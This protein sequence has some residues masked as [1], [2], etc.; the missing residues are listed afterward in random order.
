MDKRSHRYP[1]SS[2][3]WSPSPS[4]VLLF[5]LLSAL[6]LASAGVNNSAL[7]PSQG[8]TCFVGTVENMCSSSLAIVANATQQWDECW[9]CTN[10]HFQTIKVGGCFSNF[11]LHLLTP[12]CSESKATCIHEGR[13]GMSFTTCASPDCNRCSAAAPL[14]SFGCAMWLVIALISMHLHL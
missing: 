5:I 12:T 2:C 4:L 7:V 1:S 14:L 8:L 3:A 10:T 11:T 13:S 9:S 6:T